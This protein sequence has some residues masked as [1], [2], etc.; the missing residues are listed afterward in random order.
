MSAQSKNRKTRFIEA[1]VIVGLVLVT[2]VIGSRAT[3][4]NIAGWYDGLTKPSFNPPN[5]VFGPAWTLLYA[6]MAYAAWRA[7]DSVRARRDYIRLGAL[8][9]A[10]LFFN[11]LWSIVF[12]GMQNPFAALFVVVLLEVSVIAMII[13]FARY[14][15]LAAATQL[16][17]AAWVAF[18]SIL[19]LAIVLL[20]PA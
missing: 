16:P 10:Q 18:A 7:L 13:G 6:L 8:F 15:R 19:N 14:D 20:N 2:S 3:I 5:W 17:Y 11:A 4:P 9:I 1:I 12:F